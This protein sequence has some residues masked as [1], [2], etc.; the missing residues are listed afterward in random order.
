MIEKLVKRLF[1][2]R[3]EAQAQHWKTD[4]YAQHEALGEYYDSVIGSLDKYV[5]AH[6]GAL[7]RVKDIADGDEGVIKGIEEDLVW[8]TKHREEIA[9]KVPALENLLDELCAVHMKAL[10]KLKNLR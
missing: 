7:G 3:N 10:Y 5:E 2:R 9:E 1:E 4:S 8:I 6:Q